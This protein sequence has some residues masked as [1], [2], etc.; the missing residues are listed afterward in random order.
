MSYRHIPNLYKD[1]S[2]LLF[3]E[4]YAT[5][6]IHG[7]TTRIEYRAA[8]TVMQAGTISAH[9][10]LTIHSNSHHFKSNPSGSLNE[11]LLRARLRGQ[12]IPSVT[13]VGE[14]YGGAEQGMSRRYGEV[15]RFVAFDVAF[16]SVW[17]TVLQ[18]HR[19]A[20]SLY[21]DFVPYNRVP[22]TL[23]ALNAERDAPSNQSALN[24]MSLPQLREGVVLRP[25][26]ELTDMRGE[27]IAAKYKPDLERETKTPRKVLDEATLRV[28][29]DAVEIAEEW[30]TPRRL[31]HVMQKLGPVFLKDSGRVIT[32]MV[33]DVRREGEGE[34]VESPEAI[35]AIGRDTERLLRCRFGND[36]A[37][38]V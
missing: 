18:A 28:L 37:V 13:I 27:R 21:L 2:I 32:A 26:V 15:L 10:T 33:E 24:G 1:Q 5:E 8:V 34:F 22:T 4:C 20:T 23:A 9:D 35:S 16:G 7:S 29:S 38:E 3:R 25:L 30:V 31:H 17:L 12:G 11:D 19:F 14:V 6:K 36:V